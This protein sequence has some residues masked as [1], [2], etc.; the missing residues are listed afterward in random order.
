MRTE[1]NS[2]LERNQRNGI[3]VSHPFHREREMDEAQ[4]VVE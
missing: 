2:T 1:G 4:S 3:V